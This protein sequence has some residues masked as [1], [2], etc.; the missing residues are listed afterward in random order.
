MPNSLPL[1]YVR[2]TGFCYFSS[3]L[4]WDSND[5]EM[6]FTQ[7]KY[8]FDDKNDDDVMRKKLLFVLGQI[9]TLMK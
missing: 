7:L 2:Y 4:C 6:L 5:V 8:N 9:E 1:Y 3:K